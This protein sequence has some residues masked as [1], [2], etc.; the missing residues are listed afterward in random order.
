MSTKQ[1]LKTAAKKSTPTKKAAATKATAKKATPAKAT[2]KAAAKRTD[3][4]RARLSDDELRAA[5]RRVVKSDPTMAKSWTRTLRHLRSEGNGGG[6]HIRFRELFEAETGGKA[7]PAK[8]ATPKKA[9]AKKA[10]AARASRRTAKAK[11]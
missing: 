7:T 10:V 5:I 3:E 6:G 11:R 8:K 1:A 9:T 4:P 2:P